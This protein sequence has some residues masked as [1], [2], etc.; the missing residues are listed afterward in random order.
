MKTTKNYLL[1]SIVLIISAVNVALAGIPEG[2]NNK[3]SMN[4][5]I[6]YQVRI[7]LSNAQAPCNLY[8]V[9]ILDGK[10]PLRCLADIWHFAFKGQALWAVIEH[11][12]HT[13]KAGPMEQRA[14][15]VKRR[16]GSGIHFAQIDTCVIRRG[17]YLVSQLQAHIVVVT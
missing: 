1:L 2:N 6:R 15:C 11:P 4:P 5:A 8:Q 3:I 7:D 12:A 17:G 13:L 10:L 9:E 16:S 14:I